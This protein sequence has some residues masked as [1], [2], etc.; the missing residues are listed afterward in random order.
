MEIDER[1]NRK[2]GI[3]GQCFLAF[4]ILFKFPTLLARSI[5]IDHGLN[6]SF[7]LF[8]T[9]SAQ[10]TP[11][12]IQQTLSLYLPTHFSHGEGAKL[13]RIVDDAERRLYFT[14]RKASM[15]KRV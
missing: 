14:K 11:I 2:I 1:S 10:I 9:I 7:Q 3:Q 4:C 6:V 13:Q 8:C 5:T 12:K 15:M